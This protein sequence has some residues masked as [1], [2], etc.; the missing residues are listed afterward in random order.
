MKIEDKMRG[1]YSNIIGSKAHQ[2]GKKLQD[3]YDKPVSNPW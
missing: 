3:D 1:I 2:R